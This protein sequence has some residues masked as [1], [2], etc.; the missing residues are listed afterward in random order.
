MLNGMLVVIISIF[1]IRMALIYLRPST[2]N[3]MTSMLPK[4][5]PYLSRLDE[6]TIIFTIS[7][8]LV[9]LP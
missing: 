2:I 5:G 9:D 3:V 6:D 1:F 4:Q 8:H 7:K